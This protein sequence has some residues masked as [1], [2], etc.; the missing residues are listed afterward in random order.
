[1]RRGS[2]LT[3]RHHQWWNV[4]GLKQSKLTAE[5]RGFLLPT[6]AK[7]LSKGGAQPSI[8]P[9]DKKKH[10]HSGTFETEGGTHSKKRQKSVHTTT[11]F[12][13]EGHQQ[14]R[15][16]FFFFFSFFSFFHFLPP[17]SGPSH[18]PKHR[19]F[20]NNLNFKAR[21]W[22]TEER[23]KKEE[24]ADRN[25]SPSPIARTGTFCYSRAWK[26][27]TPTELSSRLSS[28]ARA[29]ASVSWLW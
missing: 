7:T 26:P 15:S 21:F 3:K 14:A 8:R 10:E 24:R 22:V 5:G 6:V 27:L 20:C 16:V 4:C 1:M 28:M 25:R 2:T 17:S 9:S 11:K 29:W 23:R 12:E 13:K 19:F 18:F